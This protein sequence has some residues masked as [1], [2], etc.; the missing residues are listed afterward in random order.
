MWTFTTESKFHNNMQHKT[1]YFV[2]KFSYASDILRLILQGIKKAGEWT[3]NE[4]DLLILCV[5]HGH[6]QSTSF[7]PACTPASTDIDTKVLKSLNEIVFISTNCSILKFRYTLETVPFG[8][9][10][11]TIH[12]SLIVYLLQWGQCFYRRFFKLYIEFCI[13]PLFFNCYFYFRWARTTTT[14]AYFWKKKYHALQT[15]LFLIKSNVTSAY[16]PL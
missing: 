11:F 7:M 9:H 1:Y 4:H 14:D 13:R 10:L 6:L 16:T 5:I 2:G 15:Y 8:K 12:Y 3:S